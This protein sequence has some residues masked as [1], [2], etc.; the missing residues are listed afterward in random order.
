MNVVGRVLVILIMIDVDLI[1]DNTQHA[2][3]GIL[4]GVFHTGQHRSRQAPLL[5][6][7]DRPIRYAGENQR[8][9]YA[10]DR[11][12]IDKN[13]I[14]KGSS[15]VDQLFHGFQVQDAPPPSRGEPAVKR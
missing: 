11:R 14:E 9:A 15:Y 13:D 3:A 4:N 8:I 2:T 1:K 5:N 7:H 6:D 10:Q 12:R